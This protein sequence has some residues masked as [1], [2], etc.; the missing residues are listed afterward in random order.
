MLRTPINAIPERRT[1]ERG[2]L[3]NPCKR[4][5]LESAGF[6]RALMN[7]DHSGSMAL[8]LGATTVIRY[9][10][11]K[12]ELAGCSNVLLQRRLARVVTIAVAIKMARLRGR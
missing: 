1:E 6:S 2:H 11:N 12:P 9:C 10:R 5:S 4:P 7:P 8:V 3:S